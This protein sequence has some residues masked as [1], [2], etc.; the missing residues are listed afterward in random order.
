MTHGG[1]VRLVRKVEVHRGKTLACA[2]NAFLGGGIEESLS[3]IPHE[4]AQEVEIRRWQGTAEQRQIART[5]VPVRVVY[6]DQH[7][8]GVCR[9]TDANANQALG[10]QH[11]VRGAS[12]FDGRDVGVRRIRTVVGAEYRVGSIACI[13]PRLEVARRD[14]PAVARLMAARAG[15][16][17]AAQALEKW[18]GEIDRS[19]RAERCREAAR[20]G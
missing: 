14:G 2:E 10:Q 11:A 1:G 6:C 17:V 20:I 8:L 3:A 19:N 13:K 7:E 12:G 15:A 16:T 9:N 18:I 4:R 5:R